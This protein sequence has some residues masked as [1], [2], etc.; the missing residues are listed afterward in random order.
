MNHFYFGAETISP[1]VALEHC[2]KFFSDPSWDKSF[3]LLLGRIIANDPAFSAVLADWREER[4]TKVKVAEDSP[5][6]EFVTKLLRGLFSAYHCNADMVSA[7]DNLLSLAQCEGV[8]VQYQSPV[9]NLLNF[10]MRRL[11]AKV[12]E[13]PANRV[14]LDQITSKINPTLLSRVQEVVEVE[15]GKALG[16][17]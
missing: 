5:K 7:V 4:L 3:L 12:A 14:F 6:I 15:K 1:E 13:D 16:I 8:A 10:E 2:Q 17:H 9:H 11:Y